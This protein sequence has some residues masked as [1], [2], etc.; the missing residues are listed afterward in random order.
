MTVTTP[1]RVVIFGATGTVGSSAARRFLDDARYEVVTVSRRPPALGD[2]TSHRHI[3]VDLRDREALAEAFVDIGPISSIVYAAL[4]EKASLVSGWVDPGQI[5]TNREMFQNVLLA[6]RSTP[7]GHL[8]VLQGTKAYGYHLGRIPIPAKESQ[9]RVAHENFYWEQEDL[10]R[11][12]SAARGLRFTIFRPQFI[13]G[14]QVG[15]AMSLIPVI[16]AYAAITAEIG[17]P[18]SFPGGHAYVAEAVDSRLLADALHWAVE[19]PAAWNETFNI[20]N[21]DVFAWRDLWPSFARFLDV[22]VGADAPRSLTEWLPR[23]ADVWARIAQRADL[24]EASLPRLLGYSHEFAD[25]AFAYTSDGSPLESREHPVLL[26]TV[27]LRQAGFSAFI[28]TEVMFQHW[29]Q[30]LRSQRVLP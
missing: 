12:E 4:Y 25:D 14:D 9:P 26:S 10:L 20:T 1:E 22:E 15:V 29:F 2:R 7:V 3:S 24:R 11:A 23:H 18:F 28:D 16:G 6:V 5:A 27:K 13:F 17:E 30:S 19:T 8:S 21:G